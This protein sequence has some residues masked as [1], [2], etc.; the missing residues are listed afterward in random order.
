MEPLGPY[1]TSDDPWKARC[2]TCGTIG[3]PRL[4]SIRSGNGGCNACGRLQ[5][6]KNCKIPEAAAIAEMLVA[7]LEPLE[8]Y[9]GAHQPWRC[10]CL[11]PGCGTIGSPRLISI[12]AGQG[13]CRSCA[14]WGFNWEAPAVIYIISHPELGAHKVGVTG[15]ATARLTEFKRLGWQVYTRLPM[16]SGAS[17]HA[18]EQAVHARLREEGVPGSFLSRSDMGR[19]G[20]YR[21]TMD[22]EAISLIELETLIRKEIGKHLDDDPDPPSTLAPV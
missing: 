1:R 21:E 7:Q 5:A 10:R 20:G 17:A 16:S 11:K 4:V 18:I 8:P 13:G 14:E 22:A 2:L 19:L 6:A 15:H 3:S 9:P 12:R